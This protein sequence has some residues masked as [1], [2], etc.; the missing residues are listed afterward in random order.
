[1][2]LREDQLAEMLPILAISAD[3]DAS[4]VPDLETPAPA[5]FALENIYDEEVESAVQDA[6]QRDYLMFGFDNWS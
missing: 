4:P 6:Y 2:I 5:F 1:M 3:C